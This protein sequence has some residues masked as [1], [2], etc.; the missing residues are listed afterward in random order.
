MRRRRR[1]RGLILIMKKI[2]LN[3]IGLISYNFKNG[4]LKYNKYFKDQDIT[5]NTNSDNDI[6]D[7]TSNRITQ[8]NS[9]TRYWIIKN[10]EN[11]FKIISQCERITLH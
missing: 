5:N 3:G 4:S 10:R 7:D 9:E 8:L 1:R 6:M 11:Q 2:Y